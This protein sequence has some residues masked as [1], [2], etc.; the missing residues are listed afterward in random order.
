MGYPH[1]RKLCPLGR[2]C[3]TFGGV[4]APWKNAYLSN[5]GRGKRKGRLSDWELHVQGPCVK[6]VI[7]NIYLKTRMEKKNQ[8]LS[9]R[10]TKSNMSRIL[11]TCIPFLDSIILSS[12]EGIVSALSIGKWLPSLSLFLCFTCSPFLCFTYITVMNLY[13]QHEPQA[14]LLVHY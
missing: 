3:F 14:H 7:E 8:R 1:G 5:G 11:G 2:S 9:A 6:I 10:T 12:A 13:L 4:D